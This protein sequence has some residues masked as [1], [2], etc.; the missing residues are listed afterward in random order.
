M[1]LLMIL[2]AKQPVPVMRQNSALPSV[3][4]PALSQR[5]SAVYSVND[6]LEDGS[7]YVCPAHRGAK[8]IAPRECINCHHLETSGMHCAVT[9]GSHVFAITPAEET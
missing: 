5:S 2:L 9:N 3:A 7:G 6:C 1:D 8:R 4:K